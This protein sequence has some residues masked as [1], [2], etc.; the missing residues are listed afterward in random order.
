MAVSLPLPWLRSISLAF[1]PDT[2]EV[3]RYTETSTADGVE[4]AWSTVATN[5]PCRVSPRA[6]TAYE[7]AQGGEGTGGGVLRA[8]SDWTVWAPALTDVTERDRI[9][10]STS[11]SAAGRTFEVSRVGART[12]ETVRECLCSLLT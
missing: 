8:Q 5:V 10:I 12:Y 11:E 9:R 7:R 6:S 1:L 4:Q 3:L 2:C